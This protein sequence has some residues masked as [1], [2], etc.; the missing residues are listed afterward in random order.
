[1][2]VL[3]LHIVAFDYPFP[4][5][6]GGL[7]DVYYK[8]IALDRAGLHIHLHAFYEGEP[9]HVPDE[10][11][12]RLKTLYLYPRSKKKQW[13]KMFYRLPFGVETRTD[14]RLLANLIEVEAPIFFEGLQTAYYAYHPALKNRA[15]YLR[16]HNLE[17]NYYEGSAQSI[18]S[19]FKRW[20]YQLEAWKYKGMEE[21]FSLFD[22]V[23]TLSISEGLTVVRRKGRATFVPPFT[24][25]DKVADL[26]QFGEGVIYYGDLRLPDNQRAALHLIDL[27]API[28]ET[29][30][31][32][33]ADE[34]PE[35]IQVALAAYPHMQFKQVIGIAALKQEWAKAHVHLLWSFQQS[36][37]K[38]KA[39]NALFCG[40][41]V[42]MN[43]HLVDDPA[44][45]GLGYIVNDTE[46]ARKIV[47]DL[48]KIPY[49]QAA[50]RAEILRKNYSDQD[51]AVRILNTMNWSHMA[52]DEEGAEE[53][54]D[55][56]AEQESAAS[57]NSENKTV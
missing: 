52:D 54:E 16:L 37:T 26:S 32:I 28:T 51:N 46:Q 33:L 20:I 1:M 48:L 30:F 25:F 11:K 4:P 15:K 35:A 44:L 9:P 6:Y 18:P 21:D 14:S 2:N 34:C 49:L 23:Y 50:H 13:Y 47:R 12:A 7:I 27:M 38:L 29:T 43:T 22:R 24:G 55:E 10:L 53:E 39:L 56:T 41:H 45:R 40:R 3:D 17:S 8:I 5:S 57:V 36:G 42:V 19:L 31:T